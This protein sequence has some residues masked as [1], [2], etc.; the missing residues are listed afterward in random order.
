MNIYIQSILT[1]II[2]D[3]KPMQCVIN[4]VE[5]PSILE[6]EFTEFVEDR[7][8]GSYEGREETT[9]SISAT[10]TTETVPTDRMT[11]TGANF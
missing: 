10:S 1:I 4:D 6:S 7:C 8:E 5:T 2:L 3:V 9:L 11:E